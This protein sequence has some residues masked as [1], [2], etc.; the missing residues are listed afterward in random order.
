MSP[1]DGSGGV[2]RIAA[3]YGERLPAWQPLKRQMDP[4]GLLPRSKIVV[5]AGRI[6]TAGRIHAA[7]AASTPVHNTVIATY[8][9][10]RLARLGLSR[11][12]LYSRR[13]NC[14][15]RREDFTCPPSYPTAATSSPLAAPSWQ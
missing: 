8:R 4:R 5:K 3:R 13:R 1:H 11:S 10:L 2:V 6:R 9:A 15:V 14:T 7:G 12:L